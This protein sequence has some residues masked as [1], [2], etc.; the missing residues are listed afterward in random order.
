MVCGCDRTQG[1]RSTSIQVVVCLC[2]FILS[3]GGDETLILLYLF[4]SLFT[5]QGENFHKYCSKCLFLQSLAM[6]RPK[7]NIGIG[8]ET[9]LSSSCPILVMPRTWPVSDKCKSLSHRFD[10]TRVRTHGFACD[11]LTKHEADSQVIWLSCLVTV[12]LDVGHVY[13]GEKHQ[14]YICVFCFRTTSWF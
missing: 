4:G 10:S 13:L 6:G 2:F 9:E 14:D 5:H 11:N 7:M 3:P 12:R 8:P 1:N